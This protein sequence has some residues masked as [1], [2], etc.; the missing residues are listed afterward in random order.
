MLGLFSS[1][2][3][4]LEFDSEAK[5]A[6]HY[7][8]RRTPYPPGLANAHGPFGLRWQSGKRTRGGRS[9]V[10]AANS[11]VTGSA[12]TSSRGWLRWL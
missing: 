2:E 12:L 1:P 4:E 11:R 10:D 5:A 6:S 8:C 7:V 3:N 9:Q